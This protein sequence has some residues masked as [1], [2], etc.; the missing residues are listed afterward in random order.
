MIRLF[1]IACCI[2]MTFFMSYAQDYPLGLLQQ[3]TNSKPDTARVHLLIRLSSYYLLKPLELQMDLDSALMLAKEAKQ[4]S[5]SL[6]YKQ[7]N[8]ESDFWIGRI[9]VE[10]RNY[11]AVKTLL[12]TLSD[13]T[14][15]KVILQLAEY[16]LNS[17]AKIDRDS[18]AYYGN[19]ALEQSRAAHSKDL[20][21]QS[22]LNLVILHAK[23][24]N[25]KSL[26]RFLIDAVAICKES[27]YP[28]VVARVFRNT[29][30]YFSND[31]E[32]F[33]QIESL[34]RNSFANCKND[35]E[36]KK[37]IAVE[38]SILYQLGDGYMLFEA[39]SLPDYGEGFYLGFLELLGE[40]AELHPAC[41]AGLC[42]AY[43]L[44]G[45]Y[46]KSLANGL[47]A[48]KLAKGNMDEI[49]VYAYNAIGQVY[50]R[51]GNIDES[52]LYFQKTIAVLRHKGTRIQGSIY[53][54]LTRAYLA[55]NKPQEA[56]AM[57]QDA[58]KDSATFKPYDM[59]V[60]A[61]SEGEA[62][63]VMGNYDKAEQCF[64]KSRDLAKNLPIADQ[65]SNHLALG[66]FYVQAKQYNKAKTYLDIL[67]KR[68]NKVVEPLFVQEEVALLRFRVDSSQGNYKNAITHL[69][70]NKL[71]HDSIF[72]DIKNKQFEELKIQYETDKKDRDIQLKT[73]ALQRTTLLRNIFIGGAILFLL[74]L[75]TIFNRYLKNQKINSILR[76]QQ[77]Q[78]QKLNEQQL[79]LLE[80]KDWLVKEIH[81]RVKNNLQI[82]MSLLNSQSS[83]IENEPALAA[84]HASQ[85]RVHAMSL[86]HQKLY[87]SE[88][89][90]SIDMSLYI[91]ELVSYL[92]ESFDVG[93]R[94][95]F[96]LNIAPLQMDVSQAVPLG[97]ILNEAITNSIKYAFPGDQSGSISISL[98]NTTPDEYLLTISD[99]GIGMPADLTKV[100]SL[101]MSLMTGLSEDLDGT[102]SIEN[103]NGTT[104][105]VSFVHALGVRKH[106]VLT[107]SFV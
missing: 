101:G 29:V 32:S 95:R 10:A 1:F 61:E 94:V 97:L 39:T 41:Y 55:K 59:K 90:S 6:N 53:K 51:R 77:K 26:K 73:L 50:Y 86:I 21:I 102:F 66:R 105:K 74:L 24:K 38:D 75:A 60:I 9:Y 17:N 7:G 28:E 3:Y 72:N 37:M 70:E 27:G 92:C 20:E 25:F 106:D 8:E 76:S 107:P 46:T 71:L 79:K 15:I 31:K 4:L 48:E 88:N 85:H 98:L 82:V 52:I 83:Y 16:K 34:W 81:H 89:V 67:S 18:A 42:Y 103:R 96:E 43:Q 36:K 63:M 30:L 68:E 22:L 78:L 23:N 84:I 35:L 12:K 87:N 2:V 58:K 62:N 100:G 91:R 5:S 40:K 33:D 13:T 69:Q 56:L 99:N 44:K 64:L 93:K 104:I 57:L 19:Q 47:K 54:D 65:L 80:E 11:S 45:D 49:P 14:R